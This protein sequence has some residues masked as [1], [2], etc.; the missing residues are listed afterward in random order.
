MTDELEIGGGGSTAVETE[1]FYIHAHLHGQ[2]ATA[3]VEIRRLVLQAAAV[4]GCDWAIERALERLSVAHRTAAD[5]PR[6]LFDAAERYAEADRFAEG[7]KDA[8]LELAW[9]LGGRVLWVA[10]PAA[11][12]ASLDFGARTA[13]LSW[14]MTGKDPVEFL[15]EHPEI[16]HSWLAG[17]TG[18]FAEHGDALIAG[19]LGL[20]AA[21]LPFLGRTPDTARVLV[22]AHPGGM[23]RE[24]PI[25]LT[26]ST[27]LRPP[28]APADLSEAF[29]RIKT[30]DEDGQVKVELY[31]LADG[32]TV[33]NVYVNDTADWSP[34]SGTE[35]F[36]MTSNFGAVAHNADVGAAAAVEAAMIEAGVSPET[37][38]QLFGYSQGGIQAALVAS[39]GTFDVVSLVTVGSPIG[40][41]PLDPDIDALS[42]EHSDDPVLALGDDHINP[43][44]VWTRTE[45]YGEGDAL[46]PIAAPGHQY[47]GYVQ[48]VERTGSSQ[49]PQVRE[50]VDSLLA[51]PSGAVSSTS[52]V[53]QFERVPEP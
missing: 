49:A 5:L 40:D 20:P 17:L 7:T 2:L 10:A 48:T 51:M 50:I 36:D 47:G 14:I 45:R 35:P 30:N 42:I 38:V 25:A 13:L 19:A 44:T 3:L 31:E 15:Q 33:A 22:A 6:R 28:D 27:V 34:W 26:K 29:E 46:P 4:D 41:I 32:S 39:R 11:L 52:T 21:A 24:T 12:L 43:A 1:E 9:W 18:D 23:L 8:A 37:K 16:Y 53:Y